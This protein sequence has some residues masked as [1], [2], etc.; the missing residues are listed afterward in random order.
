M[1]P[2]IISASLQ[3]CSQQVT[4]TFE[5]GWYSWLLRSPHTREIP[6]S[7]LG[8]VSGVI[9]LFVESLISFCNYQPSCHQLCAT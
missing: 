7:I 8:S 1:V 3:P 6:S 5:A 4:P 2:R 9:F